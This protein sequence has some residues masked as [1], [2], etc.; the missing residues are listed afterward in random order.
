MIHIKLSLS[1]ILVCL[2]NKLEMH[3]LLFSLLFLLTLSFF[4]S[5]ASAAT[6]P[7]SRCT[8]G[9]DTRTVNSASC[10][11]GYVLDNLK[12]PGQFVQG[13]VAN[14]QALGAQLARVY[15]CRRTGNTNDRVYTYGAPPNYNAITPIGIQN[16][17]AIGYAPSHISPNTPNTHDIFQCIWFGN[18]APTAND[19]YYSSKN[20]NLDCGP[21]P[22]NAFPLS[23]YLQLWGNL[24]D[25]ADSTAPVSTGSVSPTP[26][27]N[28]WID[29]TSAQVTLSCTDSNTG[30]DFIR[31]CVDQTNTCNP[32]T[33]TLLLNNNMSSSNLNPAA[34]SVSTM[35]SNYVR[36]FSQDRGGNTESPVKSLNVWLSVSPPG[37]FNF[38]TAQ[39]CTG[40]H[41]TEITLSN[42]SPYANYY[43]VT[44]SDS[45]SF[46]VN[47]PVPTLKFSDPYAL[48]VGNSYSYNV[49]AYN[50]HLPPRD[51]GWSVAF[52][53]TLCPISIA[54]CS[55]TPTSGS[56]PIDV[57]WTASGVSGGTGTYTYDWNGAA[58]LD[59]YPTSSPTTSTSNAALVR[60]TTIGN[61]NASITV[62]S[63]AA[64]PV[65]LSCPTAA[66]VSDTSAPSANIALKSCYTTTTWPGN[67][68]IT[69]S[70]QESGI[71][72][73]TYRVRDITQNSC[74]NIANNIFIIGN[75]GSAGSLAT[76]SNPAS[77]YLVDFPLANFTSGASAVGDDY[78]IIYRATNGATPALNTGDKTLAF[79]LKAACTEPFI[80]SQGGDV[81]SNQ[82][83]S[84]R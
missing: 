36:F 83:I 56:A 12:G 14:A 45:Q 38:S 70:D 40:G 26:Q 17:T 77:P 4:V 57:T 81:H 24:W 13:Y 25:T 2:G 50:N 6:V 39:S 44:R 69:S 59:T 21:N 72:Q 7:L 16:C 1:P 52:T 41:H 11:A 30:C 64:T 19:D 84:P 3:K 62:S 79:G 37:A 73:I 20:F 34:F 46:T 76:I 32:A 71:G 47:A 23:R 67:F 10:P 35:G 54:S 66:V 55:P 27:A 68:N 31:Y 75:C 58:P 51:A 28:G 29:A 78:Q 48:T 8:N 22:P 33:G 43:L 5:D 61:K 9:T 15:E 42:E 74:L 53:A 65:T 80:Q 63:G 82:S 49:I 18:D 60:Y